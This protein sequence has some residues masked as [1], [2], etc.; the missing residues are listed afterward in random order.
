M[1]PS[2][3]IRCWTSARELA[4]PTEI[5]RALPFVGRGLLYANVRAEWAFPQR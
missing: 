4:K 3:S 1:R 2:C 5:D